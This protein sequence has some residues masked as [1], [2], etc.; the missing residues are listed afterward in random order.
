[1]IRTLI[2]ATALAMSAGAASADVLA[3]GPQPNVVRHGAGTPCQSTIATSTEGG[4]R[5]HRGTSTG[6]TP[7]PAQT[8]APR[9]AYQPHTVQVRV[10]TRVELRERRMG[11]SPYVLGAPRS[12]D[13]GYYG[14]N[15]YVLG[16][17]GGF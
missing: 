15:P 13:D 10:T 2:A 9:A 4:V 14:T 16:A 3:G 17:P 12:H 7:A 11:T 8:A 1:M 5:M 6:C